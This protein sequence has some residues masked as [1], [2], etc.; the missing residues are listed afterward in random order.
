M[1]SEFVILAVYVDNINL[2]RTREELQKAIEYLKKEFEMK[3]LGKT[4][5]CLGLKIK[6][7][8]DGIFIHQY[9]YTERV[10]KRVYMDKAHPLS[11]PMIIRL[12]E[13]NKDL[14]RPPEEDEELLGPEY[15]V[16]V[17]LQVADTG[18]LQAA[19]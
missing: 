3:N 13:V 19:Q 2:V 4:K 10:L 17:Y 14:F 12:L 18:R 11:T 8:A 9:A 6:H 15:S 1:A 16:E 5:L 7:L